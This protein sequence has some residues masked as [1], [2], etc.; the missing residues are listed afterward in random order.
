MNL[1][2]I[3]IN[4][5]GIEE[6]TIKLVTEDVYVWV[7]SPV[8]PKAIIEIVPISIYDRIDEEGKYLKYFKEG[9]NV[10]KITDHKHHVDKRAEIAPAIK[11]GFGSVEEAMEYVRSEGNSYCGTII[12]Y[13]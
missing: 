6:P 2:G 1:Y 11:S 13:T 5:Y 4:I 8:N 12:R 7:K 9:T 10:L 3:V